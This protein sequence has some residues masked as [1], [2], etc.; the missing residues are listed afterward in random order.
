MIFLYL[1]SYKNKFT[2]RSTWCL[3]ICIQQN[4]SYTI[5]TADFCPI[6]LAPLLLY[7]WKL[8][9]NFNFFETFVQESERISRATCALMCRI[10]QLRG[11]KAAKHDSTIALWVVTTVKSAAA[12]WCWDKLKSKPSLALT[13]VSI[14]DYINASVSLLP[15]LNIT[16][17]YCRQRT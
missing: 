6:P 10:S 13:D 1:N 4:W 15:V 7:D 2:S 11:G 17:R 5:S 3:I 16:S 8:S 9:V 12:A 14:R